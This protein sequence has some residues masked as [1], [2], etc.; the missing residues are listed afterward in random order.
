MRNIETH[1]KQR[2]LS[3][4]I[5]NMKGTPIT[6]KITLE[7]KYNMR[8]KYYVVLNT[9]VEDTYLSNAEIHLN[10]IVENVA[11]YINQIELYIGGLLI[12]CVNGE[13]LLLFLQVTNQK[14]DNDFITKK[15]IIP[16]NIGVF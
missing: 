16:F 8:K 5:D 9:D 10:E 4:I 3:Q 13:Q 15:T 14:V 12:D 6:E 11:L 1:R 7:E 2:R